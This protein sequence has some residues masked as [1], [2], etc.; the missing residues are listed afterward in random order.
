M[1]INMAPEDGLLK[2]TKEDIMR[3]INEMIA[4]G[5][6]TDECRKIVSNSTE[7]PEAW[8]QFAL[9]FLDVLHIDD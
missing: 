7:V 2:S 5:Y 1:R 3:D 6:S 8:K 9:F 4:A